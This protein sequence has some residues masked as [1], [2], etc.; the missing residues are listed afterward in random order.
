[1]EYLAA[2]SG[3]ASWVSAIGTWAVGIFAAC[4]AFLQF[5]R[6]RFRPQV[7]AYRD[8]GDRLV[9]R[10]TNHGNGVGSIEDVDVLE[11]DYRPGAPFLP[12]RWEISG[13][14]ISG[15][16]P[17]PFTLTGLSTAQLVLLP[18]KG[19]AF[20]EGIQARILYGSQRYSPRLSISRIEGRIF[21]S[22][23]IPG[24]APPGA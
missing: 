13:Q 8:S 14:A 22:T 9:I 2:S 18:V 20:P 7:H 21:G 10:I 3:A 15:S 4:I 5:N 24:V 6:N 16:G 23:I 12:Y 19:E 1:M 17:I 11:P